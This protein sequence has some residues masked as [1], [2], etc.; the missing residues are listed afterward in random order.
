MMARTF[1]SDTVAIAIVE[2]R[3]IIQVVVKPKRPM[4]LR[5]LTLDGSSAMMV[6]CH[7]ETYSLILSPTLS[8]EG[9][10]GEHGKEA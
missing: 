2:S 3:G 8:I 1:H 9:E 5:D 6:A 10:E 4:A 7:A